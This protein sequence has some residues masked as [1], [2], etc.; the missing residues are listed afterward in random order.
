VGRFVTGD[1]YVVGATT[2]TAIDP[3]PGGGR[4]G[5][6]LSVPPSADRSGFD[7]RAEGNRHDPSLSR[8]PP[9]ALTPGDSL[10]SS[11][12][13]ATPGLVENWLRPGSGERSLSPV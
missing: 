8:W 6:V 5:S 11:V 13:V 3:A 10:A 2:V 7:D 9:V 4:N 12:S 1:W